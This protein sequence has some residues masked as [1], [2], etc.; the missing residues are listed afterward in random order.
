MKLAKLGLVVAAFALLLCLRPN[1]GWSTRAYDLISG[2][3]TAA[4]V[5]GEIEVAHHLYHIKANS[6]ADKALSSFRVG[7]TVDLVLDGQ[8]GSKTSEVISIVAHTGS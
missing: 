6:A 7:Q 8:A 2:E 5:S 4:P 3:V 1:V